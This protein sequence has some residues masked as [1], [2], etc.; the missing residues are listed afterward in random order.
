MSVALAELALLNTTL[1]FQTVH[2]ALYP[3]TRSLPLILYHKQSIA[4]ILVKAL[5]SEDRV[6]LALAAPHTIDLIPSFI[7][8][9]TPDPEFKQLQLE[10]ILTP[11]IR[12]V[13]GLAVDPPSADA[14]AGGDRGNDPS[15]PVEISKR[16]FQ[17][18]AWT[19]RQLGEDLVNGSEYKSR[20]RVAWSWVVEGLHG[21]N[22]LVEVKMDESGAD[23]LSK[24]T[25]GSSEADE[26]VGGGV[27][28]DA[29]AE[30]D[31]SDANGPSNEQ[32]EASVEFTKPTE[33]TEPEIID[34]SDAGSTADIADA[35]V[36]IR[37]ALSRRRPLSSTKPHLLRLLATCFAFLLRRAKSGEQ[38]DSM[39]LTIL[40]SLHSDSS[41]E[42][43]QSIAWLILES[44]KSV[45]GHI[46]SRGPAILRAF[47]RQACK[48][49]TQ[50]AV[51][52]LCAA[53]TGVA[54][55]GKTETLSSISEVV[56]AR[57]N[58]ISKVE[59][60]YEITLT[61]ELIRVL[62]GTRLG[63]RLTDKDKASVLTM[64][65]TS[66]RDIVGDSSIHPFAVETA[67]FALLNTPSLQSM[68]DTGR[69]LV[70]SIWTLPAEVSCDHSVGKLSC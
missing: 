15:S 62:S 7:Q 48:L 59:S 51:Q 54:H 58:A 22:P 55:H 57:L 34:T 49:E 53:L 26:E 16:A 52:I 46:H 28:A 68:L 11:L 3:I 56:L 33:D 60:R 35:P 19:F 20:H 30:V 21:S 66:W 18:L 40:E 45:E 37:N 14:K 6:E 44:V 31:L 17:V 32:Q 64:L 10:T 25:D 9:L 38:L 50:A 36:H 47:F 12:A 41:P 27:E 42:V 69:K 63:S 4:N 2:K 29:G 39:V 43:C 61:L 65:E 5:T 24:E 8:C 67:T 70:E 1:P 13:V 23:D